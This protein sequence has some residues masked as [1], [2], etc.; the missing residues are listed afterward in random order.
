MSAKFSIGGIFDPP[1][2]QAAI[3]A[4]EHAL[5]NNG[6]PQ[7][8]VQE[9]MEN[10][11]IDIPSTATTA[12]S[13][14]QPVMPLT[15]FITHILPRKL[16]NTPQYE[17]WGA[18]AQQD[19]ELEYISEH[20]MAEAAYAEAK[21]RCRKQVDFWLEQ[22]RAVKGKQPVLCEIALK[23]CDSEMATKISSSAEYNSPDPGKSLRLNLG[24]LIAEIFR[25]ASISNRGLSALDV[26][27]ALL[28][29]T[30][31]EEDIEAAVSKMEITY[32]MYVR[33]LK[34]EGKVAASG[35]EEEV[36]RHFVTEAY[37]N[38]GDPTFIRLNELIKRDPSPVPIPTTFT[39]LAALINQCGVDVM[40]GKCQTLSIKQSILSDVR[41][42]YATVTTP[43][44]PE[45][46]VPKAEKQKNPRP[47]P[48]KT[49]GTN[50]CEGA[51]IAFAKTPTYRSIDTG[52]TEAHCP[53][54]TNSRACPYNHDV[55]LAKTFI[56]ALG[57]NASPAVTNQTTNGYNTFSN[58][59]PYTG[60]VS[61]IGAT[62]ASD[63]L[64]PWYPPHTVLLDEG[65]NVHCANDAL[66]DASTLRNIPEKYNGTIGGWVLTNKSGIMHS[67]GLQCEY[68]PRSPFNI[69]T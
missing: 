18:T 59:I 54:L 46:V 34:S 7:Q 36:I 27:N 29:K 37:K 28:Y 17:K 12:V 3:Y 57:N 19:K 60:R 41:G 64:L 25:L 8:L 50:P 49:T 61:M 53:R 6:V 55:T 24:L 2:H 9:L 67:T 65:S 31:I 44:T 16:A 39:T 47:K 45:V 51:A 66:M 42:T 15:S 14:L 43:A 23:R 22:V 1:Q 33:L 26:C 4:L 48:A 62:P 58:D 10:G 35:K 5:V 56:S 52:T 69:I 11:I 40:T 68:T 13:K 32:K 63:Q 30:G 21:R 20:T 38:T